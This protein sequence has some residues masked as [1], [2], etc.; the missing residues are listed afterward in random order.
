[1][2]NKT[3]SHTQHYLTWRVCGNCAVST[4]PL[5][6]AQISKVPLNPD[7]LALPAELQTPLS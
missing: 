2:D 6:Q 7:R 4:L 3:T 5:K 1:M